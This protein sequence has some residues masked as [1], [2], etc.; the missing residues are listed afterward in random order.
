[1]LQQLALLLCIN[2]LC[3]YCRV[4]GDLSRMYCCSLS[5]PPLPSRG[6]FQYRENDQRARARSCHMACHA[7]RTSVGFT[8]FVTLQKILEP[9]QSLCTAQNSKR[10]ETRAE[11]MIKCVEMAPRHYCLHEIWVLTQLRPCGK[12]TQSF[13]SL[14]SPMLRLDEG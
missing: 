12:A 1:M 10:L 6:A 2:V 13:D 3:Q 5:L 8:D 14:D 9:V 4:S 7:V 11:G